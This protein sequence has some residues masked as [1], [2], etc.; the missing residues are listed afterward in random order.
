MKGS[1]VQ[2]GLSRV[3]WRKAL[4]RVGLAWAAGAGLALAATGT[5]TV[6]AAPQTQDDS[7]SLR[8]AH[9]LM[10]Q[11]RY[12]LA[13]NEYD[14]LL[15]S[16]KD[17]AARADARFGLAGARLYQGRYRDS[18]VA[19][20]AF[21]ND[22]PADRRARTARYRLGE[23]SYLLGEYAEARRW[24]ETFTAAKEPHA[25]LEMAWTYLG[26]SC[27]SL[28]DFKAARTAYERSL[29]DHP[30]GRLA[31]R[32]RY[33][34]GRTL[35]AL[36]DPT[37]ALRIL[38][39]LTKTG[40]PE[41][42]DRG[43]LQVARIERSAGRP[44]EAVDAL[45]KLE[46]ARPD[47]PLTQEARLE[48]AQCLSQLGRT[49]EAVALYQRVVNDAE[50]SPLA[51]QAAL[52]WS[53]IEIK[54]GDYKAASAVLEGS[55]KQ[56]GTGPLGPALRF[57]QAQ[58]QYGQNRLEQAQESFLAMSRS[59]PNDPWSD[60]AA[61]WAARVALKRG[62]GEQARR[63][64]ADFAVRFP[65][66]PL[67]AEAA[68]VEARAAAGEKKPQDAALILERLLKAN[69]AESANLP[70]IA[71]AR[72]E[73][74]LAYQSLGRAKEAESLLQG[75]AKGSDA[76][77]AA[78]AQFLLGQTRADAGQFTE[79]VP[80]LEAYLKQKPNGD[81]APFA[82]AR[83]AIA[84]EGLGRDD[85][86]G[87]TVAELG[88]R[89]PASATLA[90]TR[91]RLAE[92]ALDSGRLERAIERYRAILDA[93]AALDP[94]LANRAWEGL[95]R[96]LLRQGK[97]AEAAQALLKASSDGQVALTLAAAFESAG[98]VDQALKAYD[99][100]LKRDPT[101]APAALARARLL[102]R[103]GRHGEAAHAYEQITERF[104]DPKTL[105]AE[106]DPAAIL[107]E[108]AYA[109]LDAQKPDDADRVF[110]RILKEH[111]QSPQALDA[112]FNLAESANQ[113]GDFAEV[114][115]LLEPVADS[116]PSAPGA[117]P[118]APDQSRRLAAILFRLGRARIELKQY[119]QA[120]IVLDRL[121]AGH[122]LSPLRPEAAYLRALAAENLG[123]YQQAARL[124][125][126]LLA[127]PKRPDDPADFWTLVQSRR[128]AC[129]VGLKEWSKVLE[130]ADALR[131]T[132]AATNPILGELDFARGQALKGLGRLDDA[133]AA[134][135][136]A[137]ARKTGDLPAQAQLLVGETFFL[138]EKFHEA[139]SELLKVDILYNSPRWQAAAL[140]EAGKVY[141]RIDQ[142]AEAAETYDRLESR[143]PREEAAAE[144]KT[145][146]AAL[147]KKPV[148]G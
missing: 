63:L 26:D 19:F 148:R 92:L 104:A 54:R 10:E 35:A 61:L 89:F 45:L 95:G 73:L 110:A 78:D 51:A 2:C 134:F 88:K 37:G 84:Q 118:P 86:A 147:S 43:W 76:S 96:A 71:T 91:L 140:L 58:V 69:D 74:A 126:G 112:R 129:G 81:A 24:L 62:L 13:A 1:S 60:D 29:K 113:K 12:D 21:L 117:K 146:K 111:P 66:S 122:P 56:H 142:P 18:K 39:E 14:R 133:R 28:D 40:G 85:A 102:A 100:L 23:L 53:E 130:Q 137:A 143:F 101:L 80:L 128:I 119:R 121:I 31:D 50:T 17:A 124:L 123:D 68:L 6:M 97:G 105:P 36:G 8:F 25:G 75:L 4:T 46:K 139:L 65:K 49:P 108:S 77:V 109:L 144:A 5:G 48:Q 55:W 44:A 116:A 34:L 67:A 83:L 136:L 145:R 107:A 90:P 70:S 141:E 41:W 32:A 98:Q 125:D 16:T 131:P 106:I 22:A 3:R 115:R 93:K 7:E 33:G 64:A 72:Y 57:R 127:E 135:R 27:F 99:D 38:G 20:L 87:K 30:Q 52:D 59:A 103:A 47:S 82:L 11:R 94:K 9:G 15:A 138:Q 114:V 79:A 42:I 132:L 120:G